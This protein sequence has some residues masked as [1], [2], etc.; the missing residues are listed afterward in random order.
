LRRASTASAAAR[1]SAGSKSTMAVIALFL[2]STR[3][4]AASATSRALILPARMADAMA[5]AP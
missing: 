5:A 1:A 2:A 3:A 4:M